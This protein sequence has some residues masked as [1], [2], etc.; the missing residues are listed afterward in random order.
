LLEIFIRRKKQSCSRLGLAFVVG[1]GLASQ[2]STEVKA[3]NSISMA[4]AYGYSWIQ[5]IR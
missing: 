2:R 5:F 4:N 1:L 3:M